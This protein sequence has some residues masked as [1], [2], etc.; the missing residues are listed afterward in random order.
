MPNITAY[1]TIGKIEAPSEFIPTH[2][3][4]LVE[5]A[6]PIWNIAPAGLFSNASICK[7]RWFTSP[8]SVVDD[9]MAM[10]ATVVEELPC[11]VSIVDG[12]TG[13]FDGEVVDLFHLSS[14]TRRKLDHL[15]RAT[16]HWVHM[17]VTVLNDS[18]VYAQMQDFVRYAVSVEICTARYSQDGSLLKFKWRGKEKQNTP[19]DT[20]SWN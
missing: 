8:Q 19:P 13:H 17:V 18:I 16:E 1:L 11:L 12:V 7:S 15:N 2:W 4:Y 9:A 6:R 3:A 14:S 5:G 10:V 20:L